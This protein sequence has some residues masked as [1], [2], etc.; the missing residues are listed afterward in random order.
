M[1][2]CI[3]HGSTYRIFPGSE[4]RQLQGHTHEP[5]V[6]QGWYWQ[7]R[8]YQG[9]VLYSNPYADAEEAGLAGEDAHDADD[10]E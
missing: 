4:T 3:Y 10:W 5:A 2:Q 6:E 7:P 1:E 9:D 8:D